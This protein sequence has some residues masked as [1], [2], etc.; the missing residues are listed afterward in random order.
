M[1]WQVLPRLWVLILA[2]RLLPSYQDLSFNVNSGNTKLGKFT[3]FGILATS[4]INIEGGNS[5]SLYGSEGGGHDL[6][7][8]NRHYWVK[9]FQ[10]T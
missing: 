9:P 1:H 10:T 5:G 2:Q 4:S 6:S 7:S 8:Q 3:L